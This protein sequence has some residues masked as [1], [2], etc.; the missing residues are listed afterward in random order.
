MKEFNDYFKERALI[1]E[2]Y[3]RKLLKL[4][5]HPLDPE[6]F[7]VPS[8]V[9]ATLKSAF[10]SLLGETR[11]LG[12]SHAQLASDIK[13]LICESMSSLE[14]Q[15]KAM[16]HEQARVVEEK[17]RRFRDLRSAA[18][19]QKSTYTSLCKE[20][21]TLREE[22]TTISGGSSTSSAIAA[23]GTTPTTPTS[24]GKSQDKIT[25]RLTQKSAKLQKEID[26]ADRAYQHA[27]EALEPARSEWEDTTST[28]YHLF[29]GIDMNRTIHVRVRD[30]SEDLCV[31]YW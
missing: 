21:D 8:D 27:V 10:V 19:K 7:G 23:G 31:F 28:T 13:S 14:L 1:E 11:S 25:E 9:D 2:E 24:G 5:S 6:G 4:G 16:T 22:L 17:Q 20:L 30:L 26:V 18:H 3:G 29:E 15:I 12:Q